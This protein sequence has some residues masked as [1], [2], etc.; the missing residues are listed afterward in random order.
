MLQMIIN[1]KTST[2]KINVYF[3]AFLSLFFQGREGVDFWPTGGDSIPLLL[4][5]FVCYFESRALCCL[6]VIVYHRFCKRCADV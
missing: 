1:H 5:F 2:K 3:T 6:V 4:T